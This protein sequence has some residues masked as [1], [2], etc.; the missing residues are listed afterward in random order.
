MNK[1][2]LIWISILGFAK[3]TTSDSFTETYRTYVRPLLIAI[4][5]T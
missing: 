2:W 1:S 5:G 3:W 4:L